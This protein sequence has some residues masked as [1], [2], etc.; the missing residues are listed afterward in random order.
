MRPTIKWMYNQGS[1]KQWNGTVQAL[2]IKAIVNNIYDA[3][4]TTAM[5]IFD[6]YWVDIHSTLTASDIYYLGSLTSS[7]RNLKNCSDN[8]LSQKLCDELV[9]ERINVH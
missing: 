5:R 4:F 6:Y 3:K 7:D 9:S 2:L 1:R 8:L